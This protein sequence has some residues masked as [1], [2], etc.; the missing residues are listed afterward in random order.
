[1]GSR[2]EDS[3][4]EIVRAIA[5]DLPFIMSTERI[6][7]YENFIGRWDESKH[8]IALADEGNAYFVARE[9]KDPAGFTIVE[10]WDSPKRVTHIKRVAVVHPNQGHGRR[11]VSGVLDAI[12]QQT[13]AHRI[14]LGVFPANLRAQHTYAAIGFQAEGIARGLVFNGSEFVDQM[15]M[16]ILRPDW[17][18]GRQSAPAR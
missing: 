7:G 6:P 17:E 15:V 10:E 9:G 3:A 2:F 13:N 16:A 1:M 18:A 14:W 5:S 4:M 8:Q 11:L 12:F